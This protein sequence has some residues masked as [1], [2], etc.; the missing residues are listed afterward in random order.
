MH[1][2]MPGERTT[3]IVIVALL[4]A[5]PSLAMKVTPPISPWRNRGS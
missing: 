5:A 2:A 4:L 3:R 1:I